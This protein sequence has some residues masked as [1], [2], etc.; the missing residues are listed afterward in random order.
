MTSGLRAWNRVATRLTCGCA[1]RCRVEERASRDLPL[2]VLSCWSERGSRRVLCPSGCLTLRSVSLVMFPDRPLHLGTDPRSLLAIAATPSQS[3]DVV[4]ELRYVLVQ[5]LLGAGVDAIACPCRFARGP[6][7]RSSARRR[8]GEPSVGLKSLL[9]QLSKVGKCADTVVLPTPG[10]PMNAI[11]CSVESTNATD[12]SSAC[13]HD[14][15]CW[16]N[17][18]LTSGV[19]LN[20]HELLKSGS[21]FRRAARLR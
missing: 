9:R 10:L 17:A 18:F 7:K 20:L 4:A 14:L 12:R 2:L 5:L 21:A 13:L 1:S 15:I 11:E 16:R 6:R 8:F 19:G 3:S